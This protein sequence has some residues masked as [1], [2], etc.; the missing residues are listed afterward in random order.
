MIETNTDI[1]EVFTLLEKTFSGGIT[2]N[3]VSA[4]AKGKTKTYKDGS[5]LNYYVAD[6]G[7]CYINSGSIGNAHFK[8]P[9]LRD[10]HYLGK[11]YKEIILYSEVD[12][13]EP[14]L[15]KMGFK[16]DKA[17]NLYIRIT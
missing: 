5:L 13:L 7:V 8:V 16:R 15:K 2:P 9:I 17:Q 6:D 3:W 11:K 14:Y 12:K 1:S 4:L 10:L